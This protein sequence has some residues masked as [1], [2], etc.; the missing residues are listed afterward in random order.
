MLEILAFFVIVVDIC[1]IAFLANFGKKIDRKIKKLE[2]LQ[3]ALG[4][5][6]GTYYVNSS[7]DENIVFDAKESKKD[8]I[9]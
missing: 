8:R 5:R 7:S 1:L 3:G 4:R 6:V 2:R 9:V